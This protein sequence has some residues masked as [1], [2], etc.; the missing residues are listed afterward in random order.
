[1][2]AATGG[3]LVF[4]ASVMVTALSLPEKSAAVAG[5]SK[6]RKRQPANMVDCAPLMQRGA[7]RV[8]GD[9]VV[10]MGEAGLVFILLS[11]WIVGG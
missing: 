7:K 3:L 4:V 9:W 11:W 8:C 10:T 6:A 1:M 5:E 2:K